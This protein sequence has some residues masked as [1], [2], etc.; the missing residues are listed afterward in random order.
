MIYLD[1][2]VLEFGIF[3]FENDSNCLRHETKFFFLNNDTQYMN[4]Y[5]ISFNFFLQCNSLKIHVFSASRSEHWRTMQ[6]RVQ[7]HWTCM[8][9]GMFRPCFDTAPSLIAA[10]IGMNYSSIIWEDKKWEIS[11]YALRLNYKFGWFLI[12]TYSIW[13]NKTFI[14]SPYYQ[15]MGTKF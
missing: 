11:T 4:E 1:H 15:T 3:N 10:T 8:S 14:N 12:R 5:S 9:R 7:D 13:F 2:H 6:F